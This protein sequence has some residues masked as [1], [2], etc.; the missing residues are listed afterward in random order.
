[1]IPV[2][3]K[4]YTLVDLNKETLTISELKYQKLLLEQLNWLNA[5]YYQVKNKAIE[6]LEK[7]II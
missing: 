3:E 2:K 4:D 7:D 1:M 6:E 5:N